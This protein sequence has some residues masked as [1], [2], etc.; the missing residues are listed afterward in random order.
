MSQKPF[1]K[2]QLRELDQAL[3]VAFKRHKETWELPEVKNFAEFIKFPP[4][5]STCSESLV[6]AIAGKWIH[7]GER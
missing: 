7:F 2:D 5:P 6:V 3:L 1:S 4:I